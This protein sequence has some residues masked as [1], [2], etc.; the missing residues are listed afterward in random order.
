MKE[1]GRHTIDAAGIGTIPSVDGE[2]CWWSDVEELQKEL[3]GMR[4]KAIAAVWLVPDD[5]CVEELWRLKDEAIQVFLGK[6]KQTIAKLQDE[7]TNAREELRRLQSRRTQEG[8]WSVHS[9]FGRHQSRNVDQP[10]R[11]FR[12]TTAANGGLAIGVYLP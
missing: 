5:I 9:V 12:V 2:Y 1:I 6:D 10:L 11:I 4:A 8:L 3:E 7:L